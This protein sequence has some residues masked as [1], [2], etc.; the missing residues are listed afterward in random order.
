M[1]PLLIV[2]A[3][4]AFM[5]VS[6]PAAATACNPFVNCPPSPP[7]PP[8]PLPHCGYHGNPCPR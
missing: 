4:L 5:P 8:P 1:K 2:L 3:F 7:Q 6:L